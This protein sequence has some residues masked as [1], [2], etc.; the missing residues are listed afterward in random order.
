M[1]APPRGREPV[2]KRE[3]DLLVETARVGDPW[4]RNVREKHGRR[5]AEPELIG[6]RVGPIGHEHGIA[7]SASRE[8]VRDARR[9]GEDPVGALAKR[10]LE[11][12][13][14]GAGSAARTSTIPVRYVFEREQGLSF[15]RNRGLREAK[16]SVIAFT[17]DGCVVDPGWIAPKAGS[18][19]PMRSR[20]RS[21][22]LPPDTGETRPAI[23]PVFAAGD[24]RSSS[25]KRPPNS[26]G[27]W[28]PGQRSYRKC[29]ITRR[30]E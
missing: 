15:A 19:P 11:V 7:R 21:A 27:V 23:D 28:S 30:R 9:D 16:G 3:V 24:T 10:G 18:N 2:D 22:P 1:D 20:V 25:K 12:R 6:F 14:F 4:S 17:D 8:P 29:N 13:D 5:A 26:A